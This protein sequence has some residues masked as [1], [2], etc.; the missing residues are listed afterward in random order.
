MIEGARPAVAADLPRLEALYRDATAELRTERG[1]ARWASHMARD[2]PDPFDLTSPKQ[3]VLAGVID[4]A[5]VGSARVV[6]EGDVA[7][8][9]DIYVEPEARDV[10]V[11][12]ALLDA[13]IAW[14]SSQGCA[15]IESVALPGMRATKNFFESAGMVARAIIVYR[16]L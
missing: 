13:A 16:A 15:G 9:T 14:A 3:R 11:G 5:V 4:D 6:E 7:V 10:G 8:L 1:G 12:E 2:A